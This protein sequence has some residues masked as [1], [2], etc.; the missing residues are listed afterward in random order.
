MQLSIELLRPPPSAAAQT[1]VVTVA[2]QRGRGLLAKDSNGTS[3]PYLV[4]QYEKQRHKTKVVSKNLNPVWEEKLLLLVNTLDFRPSEPIMLSVWD[5]DIIGKDDLIGDTSLDLEHILRQIIPAAN[6]SSSE[7]A[8]VPAGNATKRKRRILNQARN[9]SSRTHSAWHTIYE[10]AA[11]TKR[12]GEVLL[13][14]SATERLQFHPELEKDISISSKRAAQRL[15]QGGFFELRDPA[16]GSSIMGKAV[17]ASETLFE[18]KLPSVIYIQVQLLPKEQNPAQQTE[19][20]EAT[21]QVSP[22]T[23]QEM[24]L[25]IHVIEAKSLKAMDRNGKSDPY[26][27]IQVGKLGKAKTDKSRK[28]QSRVIKKNLNPAWDEHFEL[29]ALINEVETEVLSVQVWDKDLFGTDDAIGEF[30]YPLASITR[31]SNVA[32]RSMAPPVGSVQWHTVADKTGVATGRLCLRH[33]FV[34]PDSNAADALSPAL[35]PLEH[36]QELDESPDGTLEDPFNVVN[37]VVGAAPMLSP[38]TDTGNDSRDVAHASQSKQGD[39][40][41]GEEG[42]KGR[43]SLDAMLSDIFKRK[44]VAKVP[45]IG[46]DER[47]P[48][49]I[50]AMTGIKVVAVAAG[51]AH[52]LL[53]TSKLA[54]RQRLI[55][56]R[57]RTP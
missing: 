43:S 52:T 17:S 36:L 53:L 2:V 57:G 20:E 51:G 15:G 19:E 5:K 34:H 37:R 49:I 39:L 13:C 7:P 41:A 27:T 46:Q 16:N 6:A 23:P 45:K 40:L 10:D 38:V 26:V 56:R 48:R 42:N 30:V 21:A 9:P 22:Q 50:S 3:D 31:T 35:F 29:V 4:L 33:Y 28:C 12:A 18:S 25:H 55:G 47:L 44:P 11:Q 54:R 14:I 24:K 8:A 1:F 32:H